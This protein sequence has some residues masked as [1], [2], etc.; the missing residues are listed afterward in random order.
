MSIKQTIFRELR[1]SISRGEYEPGERLVEGNLAKRFKVSRTPIREALNQLEKEGFIRITPNAG[2]EVVTLSLKDIADIYDIV[3]VF[4]GLANRLATDKLT[5]EQIN[6][7]EE[8]QLLMINAAAQKNLNLVFELNLKFHWL[9]MEATKNYYLIDAHRNF[10]SLLYRFARILA[11]VPVQWE[12]TINAHR[13][14]IDSLKARNP[15][16]AEFLTKEHLEEAKTRLLDFLKKN[17]EENGKG[18]LI[19]Y[20][21][22]KS[23]KK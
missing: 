13:K 6:K 14:I 11:D 22:F 7:L 18:Q 10:H 16:L 4:E 1:D 20:T 23:L 3:I 9:I 19:K 15:A 5:N 12:V 2:A 21:S 8:Y 17:E